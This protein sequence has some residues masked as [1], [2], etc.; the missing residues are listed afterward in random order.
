VIKH[1]PGHGRARVDSHVELPQ[2]VAPR[3]EL[4]ADW[5]PFQRCRAAP[6]AMTA[7][8][9]YPD[10]DPVRP[11]TLSATIVE[12]VIRGEIGFEGA[13]LSDDLSMGAL[14]GSLGERTAAALAAGCDV[15]LHCNGRGDEMV[16][17]LNAAGP[18]EGAAA[19]R[20][21]HAF[22]Q[23]RRPESFEVAAEQARF[24]G[25]LDAAAPADRSVA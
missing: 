12:D 13:L 2:V 5:L 16:E 25:L 9:L 15:A 24:D 11:A 10:L 1:L 18:L 7:H 3:S 8:V 4:A 23:L 21:E 14:G 17:V 19:A 20:V 6:F 22:G